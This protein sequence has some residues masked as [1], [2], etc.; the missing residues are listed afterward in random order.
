MTGVVKSVF[1]NGLMVLVEFQTASQDPSARLFRVS[2]HNTTAHTH[3]RMLTSARV[4]RHAIPAR[5]WQQTLLPGVLGVPNPSHHALSCTTQRNCLAEASG[6][7]AV[8]TPLQSDVMRAAS[9]EATQNILAGFVG[10]VDVAARVEEIERTID[11]MRASLEVLELRAQ[12]VERYREG[13][14]W[15]GEAGD[16]RRGGNRELQRE[17]VDVDS[18]GEGGNIDR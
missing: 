13:G 18:W 3:V 8:P 9:E 2:I 5:A 7:S 4:S 1:R 16:R 12:K 17:R 15:E 10:E 11:E 6:T 14:W